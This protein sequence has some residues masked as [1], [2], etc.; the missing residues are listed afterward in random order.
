M[1]KTAAILELKDG[2]A[3]HLKSKQSNKQQKEGTLDIDENE[4]DAGDLSLEED[5]IKS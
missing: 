4:I 1:L 2:E 5:N 3:E